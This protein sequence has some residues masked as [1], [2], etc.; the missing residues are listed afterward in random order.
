MKKVYYEKVGRKYVPVAEY[1]NDYMDSF[2]K[3]NHLVMCYPGGSSRR[4]NIE[5][6]Y[7]AMIAAGRVAEDVISSEMNKAQ[8][9]RPVS[10]GITPEQRRLFDAFLASMPEDDPHR[11]MMTHGSIRDCAEAGVKAMMEEADKLMSNPSV[12]KAYEHFQLV[13]ELTRESNES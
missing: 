6:N 12:K 5:P 13:C 1:D 8:A 11:N 4:F 10:S 3:G 9:L 2:P 7:A